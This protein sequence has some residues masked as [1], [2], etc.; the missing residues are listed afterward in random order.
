MTEI[1]YYRINYV[2]AKNQIIHL[3]RIKNQ[4]KNKYQSKFDEDTW[5]KFQLS[6]VYYFL[7]KF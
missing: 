1:E 5:G 4:L 6:N 3:S 2:I 7:L